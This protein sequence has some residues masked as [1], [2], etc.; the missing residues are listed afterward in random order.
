[1]SYLRISRVRFRPSPAAEA[2]RGLLGWTEFT[3]DGA[4]RVASVAVRKTRLGTITLAFPTRK[5]CH[6]YEHGIC[7][8][9]DQPS[10]REI[11]VTVLAELRRQGAVE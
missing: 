2:E 1:M 9:V 4:L 10:H 7:V 3:V 8:P 6:G 5:D 11:E